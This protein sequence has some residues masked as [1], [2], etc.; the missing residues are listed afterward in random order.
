[1]SKL[2]TQLPA[3]DQE[4]DADGNPAAVQQEDKFGSKELWAGLIRIQEGSEVKTT[5]KNGNIA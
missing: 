4:Q 2:P 5:E 3:G 1:M